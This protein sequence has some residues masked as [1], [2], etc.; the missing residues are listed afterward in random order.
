MLCAH[1]AVAPG[2]FL[3][4]ALLEAL[5]PVPCLR[6]RLISALLESLPSSPGASAP[7][8]TMLW[9]R[10]SVPQVPARAR[11]VWAAR[12]PA[13]RVCV[14]CGTQFLGRIWHWARTSLCRESSASGCRQK[15]LFWVP[16]AVASL[17]PVCP[18]DMFAFFWQEIFQPFFHPFMSD[19]RSP[20]AALRL[21]NSPGAALWP[22]WREAVGAA[23]RGSLVTG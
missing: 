21:M 12:A 5:S 2:G 19:P 18:C 20:L 1:S 16:A 22:C 8:G 9:L 7:A 14:W 4:H 3:P 6:D 23:L 17:A 15:M 11:G 13:A 10:L